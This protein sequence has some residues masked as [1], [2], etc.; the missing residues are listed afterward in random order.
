[1]ASRWST[2]RGRCD[3][4][5]KRRSSIAGSWSW[6]RR[7]EWG[8]GSSRRRSSVTR[9]A[10]AELLREAT[11]RLLLAGRQRGKRLDD[12]ADVVGKHLRDEP[13]PLGGQVNGDL[14]AIVPAALTPYQASRFE[15]VDD[16]RDVAAAHQQLVA[17]HAL[18]QR[19][20][21]QEGL[22]DAELGRRQPSRRQGWG[23]AGPDRADGPRQLDVGVESPHLGGPAGLVSS[24]P[25]PSQSLLP[26]MIRQCI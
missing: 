20:Q 17:E 11:E 1:M 16:G 24:H 23:E 4:G 22:E 3:S 25:T 19:S 6:R 18:P 15:V 10:E 5:K 13:A 26:R 12:G 21:V 14:P 2:C 8:S 9:L 7:R